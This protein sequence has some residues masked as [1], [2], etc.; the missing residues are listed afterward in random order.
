MVAA[1]VLVLVTAITAFSLTYNNRNS[2]QNQFSEQNSNPYVAKIHVQNQNGSPVVND[3]V[4][5]VMAG[6]GYRSFYGF[7]DNN[8]DCQISV[9]AD[10]LVQSV[11]AGGQWDHPSAY[12]L[13]MPS[14][15]FPK[16]YFVNG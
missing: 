9:P 4:V 10:W 14:E 7:T 12:S 15:Y 8:G 6:N 1:L 3:T 2:V 13:P 5:V 11:F 16:T